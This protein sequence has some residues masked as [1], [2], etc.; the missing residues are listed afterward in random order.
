MRSGRSWGRRRSDTLLIILARRLRLRLLLL[1]RYYGRL[2]RE[3]IL[4]GSKQVKDR[5]FLGGQ[6]DVSKPLF[7]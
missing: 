3:D 7:A 6:I 1:S 4:Q 2:F 5:R